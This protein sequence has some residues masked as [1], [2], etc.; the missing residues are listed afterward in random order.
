MVQTYEKKILLA[1]DSFR[2]FMRRGATGHALNLLEKLHAADLAQILHHMDAEEKQSAFDMIRKDREQ[3]GQV[4]SQCDDAT[5]KELL[6]P[7]KPA[8]IAAFFQEMDADDVTDLI[9]LMPKDKAKAVLEILRAR[10]AEPITDLLQY[11]EKTAGGLMTPDFLA[12]P[13]DM[14][15]G[16]AIAQARKESEAETIFYVYVV[17]DD[18]HLKGVISL[19][20]LLLAPPDA[21]LKSLS[22]G[23]V[24]RV[25]T[26]TDREEVA[27][28][29]SRY[30]LL[31]LPVVDRENRLVGIVTVDDV[32]DVAEAAATEDMHKVAA[33]GPLGT[34]YRKAGIWTL[35]QRRFYWLAV[36]VVLNLTSSSIIAAYEQ[37]LSATIALAFFIPLL[38]D[39]SGN[40]GSQAATMMIR[41]LVIGEI[42][43]KDWARTLMK[44]LGVGV[45]LG[46]ALA[47][48]A[49][50][51][52]LYRGGP[53]IGLI[54]GL[55]MISITVLSNLVGMT[56]PF[57][58]SWLRCDPAVA[59]SPLITS[60]CDATSLIIYFF[61]A[62]RVLGF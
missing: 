6:E 52:G 14:T 36:L 37:A 43:L 8:E 31:A 10:E 12:L 1:L 13:E 42:D 41:A 24:Y 5:A 27:R 54:V 32:I 9:G 46:L 25:Y 16:E 45:L 33:V 17:D 48:L 51:L 21:T 29:V 44:E 55:T 38:L 39:S 18:K 62:S 59:S 58:L 61:I 4:L 35:F 28:L 40:S 15:A 19:R 2:R 23:E 53:K 26:D 22:K 30:D 3:A 34:S 60:I 20:H 57:V 56:L 7:M 47:I 49:T 11:G 50:L